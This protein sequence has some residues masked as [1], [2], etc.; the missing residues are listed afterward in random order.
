MDALCDALR[1]SASR[2][3][4]NADWPGE[5]LALCGLAGVYRWFLPQSEGGI[6][7]SAEDQTRGY[8]RLAEADFTTTFVITQYMGAIRRIMSSGNHAMIDH[9]IERLVS[10]EQF[11]TVGV[12][13]LTT[14]R[15]HLSRPAML[16]TETASGFC[17]DGLSPWV[18]GA[19]H[20][21]MFVVGATMAD[22]R[23]ILAAVPASTPGIVAGKGINLIALSASCTDQVRFD[24]VAIDREWVLA[25]PAENVMSV[26]SGGSTGGLQTSTLAVGVS[27]AAT[28]FLAD[29][30]TR[31]PELRQVSA[32]LTR[33]LDQLQVALIQAGRGDDTATNCD[34]SIIRGDANR[35]VM[36]T[37][38]AALVAAKGAG[39]I[40]G[41]LAGRLCQQALFFLVWSCPPPVSQSHLCELAGIE[42]MDPWQ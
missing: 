37:T 10:G 3:Q 17:L 22:G 42:Q 12:S 7:W 4:T 34:P 26:G 8:L 41:H 15:R 40:E 11:G 27:R 32:G 18:T 31:R 35:L 2:W 36:R 24:S 16:A 23:E 1:H 33:E 28:N 6:G 29:E 20:A 19:P 21:D 39:F 30:A 13:H 9:W 5:S 14:S 38:Q 25:G